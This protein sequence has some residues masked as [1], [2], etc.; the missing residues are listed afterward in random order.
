MYKST[1]SNHRNGK[2]YYPYFSYSEESFQK[3]INAVK[4]PKLKTPSYQVQLWPET[5][6]CPSLCQVITVLRNS[7][8]KT[9]RNG[10]MWA[11]FLL[12]AYTK[13]HQGFVYSEP[14]IKDVSSFLF[15][16][17]VQVL[18]PPE[19]YLRNGLFKFNIH[20]NSLKNMRWEF[21]NIFFRS[22]FCFVFTYF[23]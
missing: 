19:T 21:F 7:L 8:E 17:V 12:V 4:L 22:L 5:C 10:R 23:W 2:N 6:Q 9:V 16:D 14:I 20:A 15:D 13:E 1:I 11:N 3:A 18:A